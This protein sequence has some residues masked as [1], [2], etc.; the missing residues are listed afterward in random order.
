[1][2]LRTSMAIAVVAVIQL[3]ATT[4]SAQFVINQLEDDYLTFEAEQFDSLT[5]DPA[6]GFLLLNNV[7]P[8]E[9]DSGVLVLAEDANAVGTEGPT[10][11]FDQAGGPQTDLLNYKLSFSKPGPFFLYMH[12]SLY[13]MNGDNAYG[14][15]DS[16]FFPRDF[17]LA[18]D[19]PLSDTNYW[20]Y[21]PSGTP[22][23]PAGQQGQPR[24]GNYMWVRGADNAANSVAWEYFPETELESGSARPLET[25]LDFSVAARE[26][27]T[28]LDR[29]VFSL[30]PDLTAE[31]LDE[32]PIYRP[33]NPACIEAGAGLGDFNADGAIDTADFQ[34]LAG[35]M[36]DGF[37]FEEAC[38]KGDLNGN[39]RVDMK[40]FLE[41][42]G[43][44]SQQGVGAAVPEPGTLTLIGFGLAVGTHLLRRRRRT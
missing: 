43:M 39:L 32:I 12:Y 18:P 16:V 15:E 1:M 37:S 29:F 44:F 24:E 13:D 38:F 19:G 34:I 26:N 36:N 10:V 21:T 14:N 4:A 35:N 8:M 6:T 22:N 11:M 40:D 3:T 9:L 33:T 23:F 28:T 2:L 7:D 42:R 25:V 31:E 41:F 17:G 20:G 27:G 30:N 5:G